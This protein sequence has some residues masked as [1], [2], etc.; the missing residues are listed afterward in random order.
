MLTNDRTPIRA[1][2]RKKLKAF[3][4]WVWRRKLKISLTEKSQMKKFGKEL[5]KINPS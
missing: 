3:K 2:S 1:P 5:V 4:I